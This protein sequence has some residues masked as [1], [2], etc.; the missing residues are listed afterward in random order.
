MK[1]ML[2]FGAAKLSG[3]AMLLMFFMVMLTGTSVLNAQVNFVQTTNADFNKGALNNVVVSSDNV[4]LQNAASNVGTWI[5]TTVLPQT[6]SGH[7]TVS[8]N[9]K[10]V[11]LVGGYNDLNYSNA[12]Y[13]ASIQSGGITNWTA[14]NPLPVAMK[15]MAVAVG[16][17]AIYVFGG[18]D[19]SQV[20]NT[21]Y[22]AAIYTD[23]TLGAWQVSSVNL[24][25]ALWGHTATY[26]K[27]YIYIVGGSSS[28]SENS[29]TGA[30]YYTEIKADNSLSSF[31][32][33]TSL[34]ASRN[35]HCTV[36]Y[37]GKLYVMGGYNN[38]GSKSS[39]VY[40]AS[41]GLDGSTGAWSNETVLPVAVSNHSAVVTNGLIIVMAGS[42]GTGLTNTVYYA[43]ADV[44][45]LT[46]NTSSYLLYDN[47][48]DGSAFQGNG[49]VFY[50]G[51]ENDSGSPILN[52]RYANLTLT[53]NYVNHGVFVSNPFYE[54]GA[55]RLINSLAFDTT[56]SP[57]MANCQLSYR[58]ALSD[59]NWS[60]WTTPTSLAN[61][62]VNETKQYLQYYMLFTGQLTYN[63][64]VHSVTL[65]TPGTQL[66]GNLNAI[67]NFTKALSPYW[68]TGDIT[69]TSGTHTFEA[70][71]TI[72]F[73]PQCGMTVSAANIICSGTAV[74]SVK[75]LY[76]TT[77]SGQWDGIYFDANSDNGV[78][79]QFSYTAIGGAGYGS[80]NANLYCNSTN[81]PLLNNCHIRG[82]DGDGIRLSSSNITVNNTVV[83]G[84][85][86]NGIYLENSNPS[87]T[88]CA[89]SYNG[90]AG[91]YLTSNV[92]VPNFASTNIDHNLYGFRYPSPNFTI[93]QPNGSPTLTANTYNGICI[94]GGDVNG[95][96]RWWYPITY[97]YILL[98]NLRII[99]YGANVRLT[100]EPGNTIKALP[101]VQIQVGTPSY[102]GEL[103]A[104]GTAD[105]LITFTSHNGLTGGW[106]GIYFTDFSDNYG[107]QS[108]LDYCIIEKGN[109]F[110]YFSEYTSQP[111]MLNHS[112]IRDALTD[113]ARYSN[114]HGSV[115][116]CQF[117]NNG[118]YPLYFLNPLANPTHTNN[119]YSG[120]GINRIALSGGNYDCINRTLNYDAM[121]YYV[122]NDIIVYCYGSYSTLTVDPG[123]TVEF[124][125]GK[126]MQ[127]ATSSSG[128]RLM[129]IGTAVSPITFKA[130]ND[131]PGGWEGI[132]FHDNSD[133]YGSS[134]IM[135]Y[136]TVKQG[137]AY[138]IY[139]ENTSQPA[140]DHCTLSNS[141]SH[142]IVEYGSSPSIH[143]CQFNDNNGY[144]LKYNTWTCNSHLQDN[145][146]SGNLMNYIALSGGT[147]EANRT[148][149]NDGIPYHVLG[150]LNIFLYS[151]HSRITIEPG[152]SLLFNPGLKIQVG[153]GSNGGDLYAEG[154]ADSII[155]FKP[156]NDAVGGWNGIYFHDNSDNYG[157][158]SSLK[159]C[160]IEKGATYNIYCENTS[161]PTM[162][163]CT[164]SNSASHGVQE[165]NSSPTIHYCVFNSNDG[166]PLKYN[167]WTCNSHLKGNSYSGNT[168][169]YI[170]LSGGNYDANRTLYFDVI[171]YHVLGDIKISL[172]ANHSRLTIQP[173]VTLLF[174]PGLKLQVGESNSGGDLY[175]EGKADS[176]IY[177]KPF[178]N[179]A[180]GWNGLYFHANSDN[181]GSTSSLKYCHIENSLD[182]NVYCESTNQPTIDH[183]ILTKST[184]N[185]LNLFSSPVTIK[186]STFTFNATNGIYLDGS[187]APT[188][189]NTDAL[190]CNLYN[191]GQY[192]VYNNSTAN[193]NA[194]YNYWGTADSTMIAL[195][196]YDKYDNT[197]KGY[198]YFGNFAQLPATADETM[199]LSGT[200]K[201]SNASE[202]PMQNASMTIKD[203]G[204]T[205]IATTSTN[206][207]GVYTFTSIP[208]GNY[209]MTITPS[210]EWGGANSTDALGILN[211]FV[212]S[213]LLT[214]MNY[215]AADVNYSHS[216][217]AT[218][219]F[220][221]MMR[222]SEL[223][224][225]FP[226]G[227]YLYNS[228][229]VIVNGSQVTNNFLMRCFGD[230]NGSY[231]EPTKS[232]SYVS[233]NYNGQLNVPSFTEFDLPVRIS[234]ASEIGAISLGFNYPDEW[235]EF[236]GAETTH[237]NPQVYFSA[238]EGLAKIAWADLIPMIKNDHETL[239]M[240]KLKTKD[241]SGLQG[242][243]RLEI[244]S[245]SEL[246]NSKAE[247][248][249]GATLEI[250]E[251]FSGYQSINDPAAGT[252]LTVYP[253][254]VN[255]HSVIEFSLMKESRVTLSI[256]NI[257][258]NKVTTIA[259]EVFPAGSHS[260]VLDGNL[261]TPGVYLLKIVL[262]SNDQS[263]GKSI[264]LVVSK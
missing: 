42:T 165:Y 241:L 10:Y 16:T 69:F 142:G 149:Y 109:D 235:I 66:S 156:Y 44:T 49:L 190:T 144:P 19:G 207:S 61:I 179:T 169:N 234:N 52:T 55:E 226:A 219:A 50:T 255:N 47:T 133:G 56:Y 261:L 224:S 21:I 233:L 128:G 71:A 247:A 202:T 183:C 85:T 39:S 158:S 194:K 122:L 43:N 250:P 138:N 231:L 74:D 12:V 246:A 195:K 51:G 134:S 232:G 197:A 102:G 260:K 162:E 222:Y 2:L 35:K 176:M 1:K 167:N 58:T 205:T 40:V 72:L 80:N 18:R 124:A 201:Y 249:S 96:N 193:C 253:N 141:A 64:T 229:T 258:G 121:P 174:D 212:Q 244:A 184:A 83:R 236:I 237:L 161:Q 242:S 256:Y 15:D 200:V 104:L 112:T 114:G 214:G 216:I 166:Y 31:S 239:I 182:Y 54:L 107:G 78:S 220:F 115:T 196:I 192:N 87:F 28:M 70:G 110:N 262:T 108:Q 257:L 103:Y 181:Y 204:G 14:L 26:L 248:T 37:N 148:F 263:S 211:H 62:T 76:F 105:S 135:S 93:Y 7:K 163:Y 34:A 264:K 254:P 41:P 130:Y 140:M 38:S 118:R 151:G 154:K 117:Q 243:I 33:G 84:N 238:K 185:G 136:C 86:E 95:A 46:W 245:G 189:G 127:I 228:D 132:Y 89:I 218:D 221:V 186:N 4:Y 191:N 75:F 170:A 173:G 180:G 59:G 101:G 5:T 177:F 106:N 123:V 208:A 60:D 157:S 57:T 68:A 82:G 120:N 9:D 252:G 175:A 147:Y 198:V 97:D 79:S 36:T 215:A 159:Y 98:G 240:L 65:T 172:Y 209:T 91:I 145:S 30:V 32:S 23:G 67:S 29:A 206:T 227:D 188:I 45:P 22:Y 152:V 119:T 126:K 217:N 160:V 77:G 24:P 113:G 81:E 92:S 116:N 203:F 88:G 168:M 223:M 251:I 129:A 17:N 11:F 6:L 150:D 48:K 125:S 3:T 137:N 146:Y 230:V 25:V 73:L 210:D 99:Q 225:S 13:K 94:D 20:Y 143:Y 53:T 213:S 131:S 100:I 178:N 187:S 139:C 199:V 90:G 153:T 27:G 111:N 155:T 171:P 8:W 259:D 63:S 164:I